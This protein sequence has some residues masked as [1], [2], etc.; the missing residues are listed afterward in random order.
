[1]KLSSIF[2]II[3]CSVFLVTFGHCIVLSYNEITPAIL[4]LAGYSL[5]LIGLFCDILSYIIHKE[6]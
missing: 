5:A 1:M 3:F 6:D 4:D 2:N